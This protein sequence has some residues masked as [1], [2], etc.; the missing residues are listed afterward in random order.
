MDLTRIAIATVLI[1]LFSVVPAGAQDSGSGDDF[2]LDETDSREAPASTGSTLGTMF[3][4]L[5][6]GGPEDKPEA[7]V[8]GP[9]APASTSWLPAGLTEAADSMRETMRQQIAG[10][11]VTLTDSQRGA[12]EGMR[13]AL[14]QLAGDDGMF[15]RADMSDVISSLEPALRRRVNSEID[16]RAQAN[17]DK[18][19][20]PRV[21][22]IFVNAHVNNNYQDYFTGG[23]GTARSMVSN[24]LEEF[25]TGVGVDGTGTQ[26]QSTWR[27]LDLDKMEK[28]RAGAETL[29]EID[30][31]R[32][33]RVRAVFPNGFGVADLDAFLADPNSPPPNG[34]ITLKPAPS[35]APRQM[36][37][38]PQQTSSSGNGYSRGSGRRKKGLFNGRFRRNR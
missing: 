25:F 16:R 3:G 2:V 9:G 32:N 24:G 5:G 37:V 6:F 8:E 38:S 35:E 28:F 1:A 20:F 10:N 23:M 31:I 18:G 12:L 26:G 17:I 7:E 19:L 11:D 13:P 30:K 36:A 15:N 21:R 27:D 29:Q 4:A 34:K 22:S 33:A 14:V